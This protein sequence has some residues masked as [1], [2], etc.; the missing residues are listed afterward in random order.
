MPFYPG[1]GVGGHCIPVDP[2]YLTFSAEQVGIKTK[3]IDLANEVNFSTPKIVAKRILIELGGDLV[4][5]RVQ[6]AGITYKP[7]VSDLRESPAL[8]LIK[9]LK[10]LGAE[11]FWFDPY[12]EIFN[13]DKSLPLDP[14][15]DLGLIIIPHENIDFTIWKNANTK[16][17]DLSAN[18]RNFGW[19]KFF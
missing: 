13:G 14:N 10:S 5:R 8:E 11:V 12:V 9:E 7:N 17:L 3:F 18:S 16:V 6:L 4:G 19:P 15:V 2:S 1:I